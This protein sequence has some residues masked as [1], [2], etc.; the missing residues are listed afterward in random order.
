M[1][2]RLGPDAFSYYMA[3]GPERSY[4]AV[5]LHFG[6][7][8]RTVT[9]TAAREDW[10]DRAAELEAKA[11]AATDQKVLE[12]IEAMNERHLKIY[13]FVQTRALEALKQASID[14]AGDAV[15][16]LEANLR[17]ERLVRGQP[18]ERRE[19]SIEEIT[20]REIAT[21][22]EVVLELDDAKEDKSD[23]ADHPHQQAGAV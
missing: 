13:R 19:T 7:T 9:S 6:V 15:R 3:L 20:K 2:P 22:L 17:G 12:T 8:K 11:R 1:N 16:A 14:S 4:Q 5:A 10:Q 18:T 23:E 21:L